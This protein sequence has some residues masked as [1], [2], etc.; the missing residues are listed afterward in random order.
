M[1]ATLGVTLLPI[2]SLLL[3]APWQG[4]YA[5]LAEN[6]TIG[7]AKALALGHAVTADP[8]GIDAIHF[9]PAGLAKIKGRQSQYKLITGDFS[10]ELEFGGYMEERQ[11]LTDKKRASGKFPDGFFND[12]AKHTTSYTEGA[13]LML[14]FSGM[15]DIPVLL[16]VTGGASYS[17]P[18]SNMTFATGV[19]TPL[20]VGFNRA[21]ND[22]GRFIGSR[23][24]LF[25]L[26]YFSPSIGIQL[27]D[28]FSLGAGIHFSYAGVGLDL[29][30]RGPHVG[31]ISLAEVQYDWCRSET[32]PPIDLCSPI[33]LYDELGELS[34]AVED[35]LS[36]GFN[37]GLLWQP[38]PWFS[39][40]VVYQSESD[41]DM[42]GEFTWRSSDAWVNL[43]EPIIAEDFYATAAQAI[44]ILGW[45]LPEGKPNLSGNATLNMTWPEHYAIGISTQLTPSI[46]LNLD[47][48]FTAWSAWPELPIS[49]ST[50]IDVLRLAEIGQPDV[51][52]RDS[53]AFPFGLE[54]SWNY[55]LGIEYQYNDRLALR[56]GYEPRD[57]SVPTESVT[58]LL[59]IGD[60]TLYGLG[61]EY[62][63]NN[64]GVLDVGLGYFSSKVEMKDGASRLG[65][66]TDPSLLIYNP[67]PGTDITARLNMI[68]FEISYQKLF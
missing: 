2:L 37:F 8:P 45:S 32:D 38:W 65:N 67:Y 40:G 27:S 1:N 3:L 60:G 34:V 50:P 24:S 61:L 19:Y 11:T 68:L 31:F 6:L 56:A 55:A 13:T 63:F 47:Y 16:G 4:C 22:P 57:S 26:T 39:I 33:N 35:P 49:F 41:M 43:L 17:P 18:G 21:A 59:P 58:P 51:A 7:N 25:R 23:L 5:V 64:G 15:T 46:K 14:P 44:G 29:N 12:E 36:I 62:Q 30:F 53:V 20:A 66:S 48:K 52:T 54:D 42:E 28:T 9:N 10:V